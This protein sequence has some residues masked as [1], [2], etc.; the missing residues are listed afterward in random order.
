MRAWIPRKWLP[1][2]GTDR[3]A[4]MKIIGR[5]QMWLAFYLFIAMS[6]EFFLHEKERSRTIEYGVV[7]GL[8]VLVILSVVYRT[9]IATA[10]GYA[11]IFFLLSF[12]LTWSRE[13]RSTYQELDGKKVNTDLIEAVL[14]FA[15]SIAFLAYTV[16]KGI[17]YKEWH[18]YFCFACAGIV[19]GA[20]MGELIWRRVRLKDL[21]TIEIQRYWGN[22]RGTIILPS[23]FAKD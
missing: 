2:L 14:F 16:I 15:G 5:Q 9:D 20:F 18:P 13:R 4:V 22:T 3:W 11:A 6:R 21:T 1:C 10:L 23:S 19:N 8:L 17:P 12:K 7:N